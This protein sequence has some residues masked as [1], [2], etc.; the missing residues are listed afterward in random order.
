MNTLSFSR[1]TILAVAIVALA[2]IS[3]QLADVFPLVFG[4][5]VVA[6]TLNALMKPVIH[7]TGFSRRIALA[8]VIAMLLAVLSLALWLTGGAV[9]K[10]FQELQQVLPQALDTVRKQV[11]A[12]PFSSVLS[13]VR[14]GFQENGVP[15]G[16]VASVASTT[17]GALS[18]VALVVIMGI[19]LAAD[20]DLYRRGLIRLFPLDYRSRLE[21]G[22]E[23]AHDGLYRW[24]LGQFC[25]ML[26]VGTMTTVGLWLLGMPLATL[27]GLIAGVLA[28]VAFFGPIVSGILAVLLAF[29]E[30]PQDALYVAILFLAI[31]QVEGN[32]LMPLLQRWAVK[33]PPI[34]GLLSVVVFGILFGV[35]GVLLA[36]PLIVVCMILTRKLYV[37]DV[38]EASKCGA[39]AIPKTSEQ[40]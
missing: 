21:R 15:W 38:L 22:L 18:T 36:T 16:G 1:K 40:R 20:P 37:E 39:L 35:A 33:L 6:A 34:L 3:W 12:S 29:T 10:Q 13:D 2:F 27:L 24:L 19:Y 7:L 31:Q 4:M 23:A 5:M 11:E 9:S 30:G 14:D 25:S 17:V 32:I 26:A 28:F 8:G